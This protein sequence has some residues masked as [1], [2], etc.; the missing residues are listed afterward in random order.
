MTSF[1]TKLKPIIKHKHKTI[2]AFAE[3]NGI[4]YTQVSQYL[5]NRTPSME[6]LE[7]V[8]REFPEIDLNWLLREDNAHSF[9]L[10]NEPDEKYEIQ[11]SNE[12]IV[13]KIEKLLDV[14]KSNLSQK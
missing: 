7:I 13:I 12:D 3:K 4:N 11:M 8:M 2:S 6:F 14:L 5:N 1:G 10:L 9:F